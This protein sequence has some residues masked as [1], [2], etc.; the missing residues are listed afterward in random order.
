[1]DPGNRRK[2]AGI[3]KAEIHQPAISCPAFKQTLK[4]ADKTVP[5]IDRL[6]TRKVRKRSFAQR[7]SA[8]HAV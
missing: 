5:T 1:L 2:L 4:R 8:D 6:M 3:R 7:E